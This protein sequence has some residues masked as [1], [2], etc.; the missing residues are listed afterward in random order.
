MRFARF[1]SFGSAEEWLG[2]PF[3]SRAP[4]D[5]R[6]FERATFWRR[7]FRLVKYIADPNPVRSAEGNVPRQKDVIEFED[8]EISRIEA[9]R[10]PLPDCWTRVLRRSTGWRRTA[11]RMPDPRPAAKLWESQFWSRGF[12]EFQE[13]RARVAADCMC[14]S[15]ECWG[16]EIW[17]TSL[18]TG[19]L[20]HISSCASSRWKEL[21][22]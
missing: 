11:E 4:I 1:D 3:V 7:A 15:T 22:S 8:F 13:E 18:H 5:R 12:S 16:R 19:M 14:C 6:R 9:S 10:E 2:R 17:L 20:R 21:T